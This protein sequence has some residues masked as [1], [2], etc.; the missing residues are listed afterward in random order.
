MNVI[1]VAYFG[2]MHK[3]PFHTTELSRAELYWAG[4]LRIH[5]SFWKGRCQRKIT[6][7]AQYS[8]GGHGSVMGIIVHC[9]G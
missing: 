6:E 4:R 7:T 8:S 2:Q 3:Y 5:H 9:S 1:S